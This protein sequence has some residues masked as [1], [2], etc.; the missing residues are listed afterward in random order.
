MSLASQL[1][2]ILNAK[3][4]RIKTGPAFELAFKDA[5]AQQSQ[6]IFE[7]GKK[8]DGSTIGSYD[9]KPFYADPDASPKATTKKGKRGKAIKG[10]YYAGGYRQYRAQQGREAGFVNLRL[11]NE[12]QSDY[13]NLN[14]SVSSNQV[15][16]PK[17]TVVTPLLLKVV[18]KKPINQQKIKG[19]E[20]KYGVI[21]NLS[22]SEINTL[23]GSFRFNILKELSP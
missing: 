11:N 9:S 2:A 6:R 20:A 15:V 5:L 21:F 4:A 13:A 8:T 1:A 16:P 23:T 10:G 22:Q 19:L 14:I 3:L 7:D 17:P 18:I 12:L